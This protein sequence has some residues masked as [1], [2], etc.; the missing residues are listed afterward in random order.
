MRTKKGDPWGLEGVVGAPPGVSAGWSPLGAAH[1]D[2]HMSA[3]HH[4]Q[5]L[6]RRGCSP[7]AE[8]R[9]LGAR[10]LGRLGQLGPGPSS[11]WPRTLEGREG[12]RWELWEGVVV[13]G[14]SRERPI[15]LEGELLMEPVMEF[16]PSL[17]SIGWICMVGREVTL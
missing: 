9:Q 8:E 2:P 6:G 4:L 11:S 5:G 16:L 15:M 17:E 12:E 1:L 10:D 13:F 7:E 14:L 3:C